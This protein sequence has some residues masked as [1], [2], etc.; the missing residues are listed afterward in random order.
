MHEKETNLNKWE[1]KNLHFL[2]IH[3]GVATVID[4]IFIKLFSYSKKQ[5]QVKWFDTRKLGTIKIYENKRILTL[6]ALKSNTWNVV[7]VCIIH[8]SNLSKYI[9]F[10]MSRFFRK[11]IY[12]YNEEWMNEWITCLG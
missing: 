4:R 9:S 2:L 1:I 3:N 11:S 10:W 6:R 8:E 7:I 5:I 12:A